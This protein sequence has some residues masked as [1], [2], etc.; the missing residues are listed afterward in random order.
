MLLLDIGQMQTDKVLARILT[1]TFFCD[2]FYNVYFLFEL[3]MF[4]DIS[5]QKLTCVQIEYVSESGEQGE[6]YW[7]AVDYTS[8]CSI[9]ELID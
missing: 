2:I 1:N 3:N 8:I 5:R 4:Q 9:S 7:S 6:I